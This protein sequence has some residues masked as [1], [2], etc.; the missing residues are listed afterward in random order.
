MLT[1]LR[2]RQAFVEQCT[3]LVMMDLDH[4][5]EVNDSYGHTLGDEFLVQFA[6]YVM[7]Q[8]RP[9]RRVFPLWGRKISLPRAKRRP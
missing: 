7:S 9:S 6:E 3:C 1:W 4:L 2:E 8:L 5:Q